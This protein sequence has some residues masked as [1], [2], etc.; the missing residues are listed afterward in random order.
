MAHRILVPLTFAA[1]LALGLGVAACAM[2]EGGARS[3]SAAGNG[4]ECFYPG[5]VSTFRPAGPNAVDVEINRSRV[6]RLQLSGGCTDINWANSVVLRSRTGSFICSAFD[7][8]LI[9][10]TPGGPDRCLVT[11]IRRLGPDEIEA[12]RR[13]R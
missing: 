8:E 10:P 13:N 9:A 12:S 2:D 4:S 6:Y 11:G 3:A 7:A 1:S 5:R